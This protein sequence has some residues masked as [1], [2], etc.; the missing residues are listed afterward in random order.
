MTERLH[1]TAGKLNR[2]QQ[3]VLADSERRLL[4]SMCAKM[5][6]WVTPD[7]LTSFGLAGAALVGA[8]YALSN[9]G[10]AW[11]LLTFVGYAMQWF[12]D[13]MDGSLAR[14]RKIERPSYGYFIDHSCDA[15][16]I[17]FILG[18]MGASPY[19][20]M[21][22][23]L[24]ALVGYLM[25]SI[26]AYLSARVLGELKLSYL[27][28]GPT[29]LRFL[30][31]GLTAMMMILGAGSGMF[32]AISGFDIFVG[33]VAAI[34]VILFVLQTLSSGRRLARLGG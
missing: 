4:I 5:P 23:A 13:S 32:G 30:L 9:F 3:N 2:I 1:P 27:A 25:L 10:P 24:F 21:D 34:L 22:V 11:L 7:R 20:T 14:F 15:L 18:G 8:G 28:A 26:H 17:L 33:A 31:L 16:T 29:E 6:A 12:G 19:V